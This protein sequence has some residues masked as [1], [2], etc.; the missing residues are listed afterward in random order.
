[1]ILPVISDI[2]SNLEALEK[3]AFGALKCRA[4]GASKTKGFVSLRKGT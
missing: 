4:F 1:M 2:H 3:Y